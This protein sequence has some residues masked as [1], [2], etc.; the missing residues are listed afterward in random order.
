MSYDEFGDPRPQ[1]M[2]PYQGPSPAYQQK[3]KN[4]QI[5]TFSHSP[6]VILNTISFIL[7]FKSS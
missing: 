4:M 6:S 3:I 1:P 2:S 5:S 7:K